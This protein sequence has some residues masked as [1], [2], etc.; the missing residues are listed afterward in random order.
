[1]NTK[2]GTNG[3][4]ALIEATT[5]LGIAVMALFGAF[6]MFQYGLDTIRTTSESST[7]DRI[8]LNELETLRALPFDALETADKAPFHST[9]P[10]RDR[11][12]GALAY[13]HIQPDP[14]LPSQLKQVTVVL[15]WRTE[16]GRPME[17]RLTT[18]I[19][20]RATL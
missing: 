1:M 11:L 4:F 7:A 10:E 2:V 15:R 16:R 12:P 5:A 13:V 18:L 9:S 3:G 8:V 14:A 19:A 17:R 6:Q 20:R